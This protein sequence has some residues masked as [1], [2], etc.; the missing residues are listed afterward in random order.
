MVIND[1]INCLILVIHGGSLVH[2]ITLWCYQTW[3]VGKSPNYMELSTCLRTIIELWPGESLISHRFSR[4]VY[5]LCH[6]MP[7]GP[8]ALLIGIL[9]V[10]FSPFLDEAR[11]HDFVLII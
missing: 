2:G 4:R 5:G 9:R 3:L 6:V 7:R 11:Y 1:H 8:V 10:H